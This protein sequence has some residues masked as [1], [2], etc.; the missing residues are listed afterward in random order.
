ML[1]LGVA[2]LDVLLRRKAVGG[3]ADLIY[4][5][6]WWDCGV[7]AEGLRTDGVPRPSTR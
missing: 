3:M 2:V 1:N 7:I 4:P 6:D 5:G